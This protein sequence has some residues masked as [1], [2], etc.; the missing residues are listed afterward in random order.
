[1]RQDAVIYKT[2]GGPQESAVESAKLPKFVFK[3]HLYIK[4]SIKNDNFKESLLQLHQ[5][6]SVSRS[7]SG[8][9]N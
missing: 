1:M 6:S 3:R 4:N 9:L 7:T 8:L 2:L 5:V